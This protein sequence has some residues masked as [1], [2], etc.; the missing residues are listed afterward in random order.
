M[1]NTQHAEKT[2]LTHNRMAKPSASLS[3]LKARLAE[4]KRDVERDDLV[5]PKK[6]FSAERIVTLLRLPAL[7]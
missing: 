4:A 5:M 3:Q 1:A 6:S 2:I 7:H